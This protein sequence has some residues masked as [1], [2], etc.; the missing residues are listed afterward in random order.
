MVQERNYFVF[1]RSF[2]D[3]LEQADKETQLIVYRAIACY[4]LDRVEP[5]L[6][7]M[8]KILWSLIRPQLDANWKR[9][10]NGCRGGAPK[11]NTNNRYSQS[12]EITTEVQPKYNQDTTEVQPNNRIKNIKEKNKEDKGVGEESQQAKRTAFVPPSLKEVEDF[13]LS[14]RYN[15]NASAFIN[16]YESKGWMI[17]KN[18][19]KDWKA[20]V[21]TWSSKTDHQQDNASVG[22]VLQNNATKQYNK[23]DLW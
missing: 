7:G 17:G 5:E 3:A 4:A 15:V 8:A 10:D 13:I 1:Y 19:M 9:F 21:R 14:N 18:K 22:V 12:N 2:Y 11:G 23:G 20:A 6:D 16:F